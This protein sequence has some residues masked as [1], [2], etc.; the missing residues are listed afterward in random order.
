MMISLVKWWAG[1][2]LFRFAHQL[3]GNDDDNDLNYA[4]DSHH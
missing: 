1:F 2:G 3:T 4:N